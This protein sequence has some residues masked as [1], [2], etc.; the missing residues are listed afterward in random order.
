MWP[1][2]DFNRGIMKIQDLEDLDEL[3]YFINNDFIKDNFEYV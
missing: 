3:L 1:S 2:I